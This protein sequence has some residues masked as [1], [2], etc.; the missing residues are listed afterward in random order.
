MGKLYGL[1][2]SIF[3]VIMILGGL[4][5]VDGYTNWKGIHGEVEQL[6]EMTEADMQRFPY[7]EESISSVLAPYCEEELSLLHIIG[8]KERY[9]LIPFPNEE[10]KY[11]SIKMKSGIFFFKDQNISE[12]E[13]YI[14]THEGQLPFETVIQG[15][16]TAID[17]GVQLYMGEAVREISGI[18]DEETLKAMMTPY[19]IEVTS[20]KEAKRDMLIG[21]VVFG[22]C[23]FFIILN[24]KA[25]LRKRKRNKR[26]QQAMK[27]ADPY[28]NQ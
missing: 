9:Y 10:N 7:V 4:T 2:L 6:N 11:M 25:A 3:T 20:D 21:G 14:L 19:C 8:I 22:S 13:T 16:L 12:I 26:W 18:R 24:I 28:K 17:N 15:R 27:V 5:L 1:D 23:V